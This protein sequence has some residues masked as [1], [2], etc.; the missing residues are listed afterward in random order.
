MTHQVGFTDS[1][2][3]RW[4]LVV[5]PESFLLGLRWRNALAVSK[6]LLILGHLSCRGEE[7]DQ[8][9]DG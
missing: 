1:P 2:G 5:H 6:D 8:N 4:Q 3:S 7:Q 9:R